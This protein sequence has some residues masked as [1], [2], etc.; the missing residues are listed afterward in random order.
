MV[1]SM[2]IYLIPLVVLQSYR[3]K[4]VFVKHQTPNTEFQVCFYVVAN[5]L[6]PYFS[7]LANVLETEFVSEL[8]HR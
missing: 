6:T 4:Y 1:V 3:L 5:F 2:Q 7:C 8:V